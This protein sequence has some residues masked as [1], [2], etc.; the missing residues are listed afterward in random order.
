ML[1]QKI[2]AILFYMHDREARN[3][4]DNETNERLVRSGQI[5]IHYVR[6]RKVLNRNSPEFE[7]IM[8]DFMAVNNKQF[9]RVL[10]MKVNDAMT[11]KAEAGW[12]PNNHVPL[13]YVHKKIENENG[14]E[15]KRGTII[16]R[17]PNQKNVNWVQR[18][19]ELRAQ[20]YTLEQIK[21][22]VLN[23]NLVPQ[24]RIADYRASTIE[25][26]MKNPFYRGHVRWKGE[27][28]KGKHEIIIPKH[29]LQKIDGVGTKP[30]TRRF[31]AE[32]GILAG[33][34][35]K[36][37]DPAC[38][39]NIVYDPKTKTNKSTG[40]TKT[41]KY[42][43][44]TNGRKIHATMNGM[45]VI[46]ELIWSQLQSALDAITVSEER[47]AEIA[48]EL[49][50]L[51]R[52]AKGGASETIQKLEAERADLDS[53]MN[54]LVDM[55]SQSILQFRWHRGHQV[56]RRLEQSLPRSFLHQCWR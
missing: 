56:G 26:R 13:G 6:D 33:G 24:H 12:F 49:N 32:V 55:Q 10:S 22:I 35:M 7:Y 16:V 15:S 31:T 8:R 21:E 27:I 9:S 11:A 44:C 19:F 36:C 29:I 40:Q 50:V 4:T 45:N 1:K 51:E 20:G 41:F 18:E 3:L 14:G 52:E 2:G 23:E 34:W 42:Y 54:K 5:E 46:E 43:H 37:A 48:E 30:Y 53:R 47:A 39:C 38:R 25:K 17:D 28:Y